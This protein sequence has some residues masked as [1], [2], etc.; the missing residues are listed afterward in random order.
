[1]GAFETIPLTSYVTIL[2]LTF[3]ILLRGVCSR[4]GKV[5][6]AALT[7]CTKTKRD[8]GMTNLKCQEMPN[9]YCLVTLEYDKKSHLSR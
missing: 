6:K 8:I 2:R 4:D 9:T 5:L 7:K 3:A 1:M